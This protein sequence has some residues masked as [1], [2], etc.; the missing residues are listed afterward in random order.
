MWYPTMNP[1]RAVRVPRP[2]CGLMLVLLLA[3]VGCRDA[4]AQVLTQN[5]AAVAAVPSVPS[6][7]GSNCPQNAGFLASGWRVINNSDGAGGSTPSTRCVT[8]GFPE[9]FSP[10]L[11]FDAQDESLREFAGMSV[12]AAQN[13]NSQSVSLWMISPRVEFGVG[14]T[15]EFWTR[16]VSPNSVFAGRDRMQVRLMT[17]AGSPD[18]GATATSVGQFNTLLLD[19][20]PTGSTV[21]DPCTNQVYVDPHTLANYPSFGWCRI[22]LTA[23]SGLPTQGSGYIAFRYY[24]P[25]VATLPFPSIIGIDTLSFDPGVVPNVAPTL[26]FGVPVGSTLT[27]TGAALRGSV[28]EFHIPIAIDV[29]GSGFGPNTITTL[30]CNAPIA[31]IAGFAQQIVAQPGGVISHNELS[32]TCVRGDNDVSQNLVCTLTEGALAPTTVGFVLRCPAGI[33]SQAYNRYADAVRADD[34][35]L[36]WRLGESQGNA[37]NAAT[38]PS[39]VGATGD[40]IVLGAV[41]RNQA[42]VVV[43]G[44]PGEGSVAFHSSA[45]GIIASAAFDK[46]PAGA[47]GISL[48]TWMRFDGPISD[49]T[50]LIGDR[51]FSLQDAF[52][53]L[54]LTPTQQLRLHVFTNAGLHAIDTNG[55][56]LEAGKSYHLVATWDASSGQM[57]IYIN[58]R[59]ASIAT[60][61]GT[62]PTTG[63]GNNSA[64]NSIVI[65]SDLF[66]TDVGASVRL[67]ETAVYSKVLSPQRIQAHY[68]L[69]SLLNDGFDG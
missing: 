6:G 48:E 66:E 5:F 4:D 54:Y 55:P 24:T 23:V 63:A 12:A 2:S 42:A 65:G 25:P 39:S 53:F 35:R 20:N 17:A 3:A 64:L 68:D 32:G 62:N 28:N 31:P 29:Q 7:P 33:S 27:A 8:Q 59:E 13:S 21:L 15:L 57:R 16:T 50:N 41:E 60:S 67:D 52:V 22:R 40:G 36:Y 19:I 44:V 10:T 43:T 49:F 14:A 11:T 46:L 34:P 61:T 37:I 58:G 56:L 47:G 51:P 38:G 18:V 30:H 1:D 9:G 26:S 45:S 69:G